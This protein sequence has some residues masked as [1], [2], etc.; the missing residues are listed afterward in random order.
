VQKHVPTAP[1]DLAVHYD[2]PVPPASISSGGSFSSEAVV[3][4]LGPGSAAGVRV[5]LAFEKLGALRQAV[6]ASGDVTF[7]SLI[8]S[9]G[10]CT[11][12]NSSN[13]FQVFEGAICELG[14]LGPGTSAMVSFQASL[15]TS[16]HNNQVTTISTVWGAAVGDLWST[17]EVN[18]GNNR[19]TASTRVR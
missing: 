5:R 1:I 19:V 13:P 12:S 14:T 15:S 16:L 8:T 10:T 9:Q 7:T 6:R 18:S 2:R 3:R 4:N 11:V 17:A